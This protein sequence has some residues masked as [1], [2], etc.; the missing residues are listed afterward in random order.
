[1][2][3]TPKPIQFALTGYGRVAPTHKNAINALG[4]D[5]KLATICDSNPE[6][7]QKGIEASGAKGYA[8]LEEMLQD[9]NVDVVSICTPSGLHAAHGKTAARAGK[10]VLV[11]KPMDVSIEAAQSLIDCCK[12]EGVELF[13]VFQN[14]LNTTLKLL[15]AA[16]D[17][18]RFGKI[19]AINSTVIW[20]RGQE[21][22][23]ADAWRGTK[24]MDG[25]AYLNQGIHFVDAMRFLCGEV[26]EI[27]SMLGTLARDIESEDTG[28]ALLRFENGT[29]GN[30]FVTMLG[31][32]DQEGSITILGEKGTVCISGNA[33]NRIEQWDFEEADP[34]QDTLAHNADYHTKSV[35][36]F[37]H[38]AY[39]R[40][41]ADYLLGKGPHPTGGADGIKSLGLIRE[42]YDQGHS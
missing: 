36:G 3:T 28:S 22:Y 8:S 32:K 15:K 6:N 19:Y 18:G 27:K 42:I 9:P 1:M 30:I 35:Y 33:M 2:P 13:C 5:A 7:L 39:Y 37:G 34:E 17:A 26:V 14:R 20:K 23:D 12:A 11:E 24:A 40:Q 21:Y 29:L 38:Q 25:G 31:Q 41:V 4:N 16:I 10:H